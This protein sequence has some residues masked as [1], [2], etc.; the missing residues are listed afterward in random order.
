MLDPALAV[1]KAIRA[2]LTGASAVVAL[3]SASS[4]LDRNERPAPSPSIILGED[5]VIDTGTMIDR[6]VV[7]VHSTIHIW[8]EE[9]GLTGVKAIAGAVWKAIKTGRLALDS[10]LVCGDCRVN[11]TRFIR[12]PDGVTSHGIVTVETLVR[13]VADA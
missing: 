9:Q 13:E 5:Q 12:D 11:D 10:G 8:K 4:I 6:S 2:R 3:V 1:Q 7:R